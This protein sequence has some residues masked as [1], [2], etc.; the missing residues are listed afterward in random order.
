MALYDYL[1][2]ANNSVN[3]DIYCHQC[4]YD[5]ANDKIF[6]VYK[7]TDGTI[8]MSVSSDK[9]ESWL[10]ETVESGTSF[11]YNPSCFVDIS[12]NLHVTWEYRPTVGSPAI[13]YR[14]RTSAGSWGSIES[15]GTLQT[16]I[17][18]QIS[19]PY[20]NSS[21]TIY[22]IH[23]LFVL[24]EDTRYL[25]VA[26]KNGSWSSPIGYRLA[27][28]DT[29]HIVHYDIQIVG[30]ILHC[31]ICKRDLST[32]NYSILYATFNGTTWSGTTT[33]RT[34]A[35][36]LQ[37][38]SMSVNDSGEIYIVWSEGGNIRGSKYTAGWSAPATI[39]DEANNLIHSKIRSLS[40]TNWRL[41]YKETIGG[42][43][44]YYYLDYTGGSWGSRTALT[45]QLTGVSDAFTPSR[46]AEIYA[47]YQ[48]SLRFVTDQSAGPAPTSCTPNTG[49][50]TGGITVTIGGSGFVDGAA[51]KFGDA[52]TGY[53]NATNVIVV[54]PSTI[55]CTLPALTC[56]TT[57]GGLV[58]V[59]VTNPD[60]SS[61]T[62]TDGFTYGPLICSVTP[63][64]G[65]LC[66]GLSV[67]IT[68]TGFQSGVTVTFNGVTADSIVYVNTYTITCEIPEYAGEGDVDIVVTNPDTQ[69]YTLSGGFSYA[70]SVASVPT[71]PPGAGSNGY[72]FAILILNNATVGTTSVTVDMKNFTHAILTLNFVGGSGKLRVEV[73]NV[74]PTFVI[75]STMSSKG[76]LE[77]KGYRYI[78]ATVLQGTVDVG[79]SLIRRLMWNEGEIRD[80]SQ[81][82]MKLLH[83]ILNP[84]SGDI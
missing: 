14:K 79:L 26:Q 22:A 71:Q 73:S 7:Y 59:V 25:Q 21:G 74:D 20:V 30:D 42:D 70:N 16:F 17:T 15:A 67:T 62:L 84:V 3:D 41:F 12:G 60:L 11:N 54:D 49:A 53:V 61:G 5:S 82:G 31:V 56:P 78:R 1:I 81:Y 83:G 8:R 43:F 44:R 75:R 36:F 46:D 38:V 28:A 13:K 63:D 32:G 9:G 4:V 6:V 33:I 68:G 45:S 77:I 40:A 23:M 76:S 66:G 51:V 19:F 18:E 47:T 58:D 52:V 57:I 72:G 27:P 55:T 48:G 34:A 80:Q 29:D 39:A 65:P 24:G 10:E 35:T 69:T 50:T 2:T 37:Y 64:E